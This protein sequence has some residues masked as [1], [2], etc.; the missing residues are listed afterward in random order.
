MDAALSL[1]TPGLVKFAYY[2]QSAE[3]DEEGFYPSD[4]EA[5][6]A[7]RRWLASCG[8]PD[9]DKV[10]VKSV[11]P[12]DR[13][14]AVVEAEGT[15]AFIMWTKAEGIL[16]QTENETLTRCLALVHWLAE[17]PD[18]LGPYCGDAVNSV[19]VTTLEELVNE[20]EDVRNAYNAT[21]AYYDGAEPD[22]EGKWPETYCELD[23]EFWDEVACRL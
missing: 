18:A 22:A 7:E 14:E 20:D 15:E 8:A 11:L 21:I 1:K 12:E 10:I 2:A 17:M 9:A 5:V 4:T 6:N 19:L 13:D 23:V 16:V 3:V